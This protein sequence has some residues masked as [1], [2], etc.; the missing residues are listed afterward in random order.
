MTLEIRHLTAGYGKKPVI[1]DINM[2]AAAGRIC[3]IMGRNGSGKTTLLRCINR[4]LTLMAGSIRI[5][6]E[7]IA[8]LARH[9]IAQ[10][11]SVVP[12]ANF[13]PFAFSCLDMVLMAGAPR[14]RAWA[15][16]SKKETFRAAI[17]MA[18]VG[19]DH[20]KNQPFNAVSGG[21]RQLVMLARAL[22]Q[23]T[24]IM[25]LDEPTAHLDFANQHRI[26]ALMHTLARKRRMT[27]AITLH[28]PNLSHYYC[29]DV[30]LIHQGRIAAAGKTADTLT[31]TVLTQ[32]LGENIQL[33]V[34]T[35][36]VFVAVPRTIPPKMDGL[37]DQSLENQKPY[38]K[39]V[40]V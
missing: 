4:V 9:H 17:A 28:D 39:K 19:I 16:P 32:V 6:G 26:M 30:V 40:S 3:A 20:M 2:T 27:V 18:D 34:T 7:D 36:G 23:Q 24:P 13:S 25:L 38:I 21:E 29:D 8:Q 1:S 10:K 31:D 35:K 5:M 22:F 11:I 12:Q 15:A 37:A 14:I 33:D